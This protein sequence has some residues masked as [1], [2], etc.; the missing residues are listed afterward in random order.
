ME[1]KRSADYD[2]LALRYKAIG[3][4]LIKMEGLVTHSNSGKNPKLQQYYAHWERKIYHSITTVSLSENAIL[5][6]V[7]LVTGGDNWTSVSTIL[8]DC[9]EPEVLQLLDL[10][11]PTHISYRHAASRP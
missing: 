8:D 1:Q 11:Q 4:L 2:V 9:E 7:F 6:T 5:L 10:W 3:P